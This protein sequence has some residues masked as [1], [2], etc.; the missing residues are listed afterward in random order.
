[1]TIPYS[2]FT[3]MTF[4]DDSEDFKQVIN[5]IDTFCYENPDQ[6][7]ECDVHIFRTI[8]PLL[9]KLF[10][11]SYQAADTFETRRHSLGFDVLDR[12]TYPSVQPAAPP[13]ALTP[14]QTPQTTAQ[15]QEGVKK[16]KKNS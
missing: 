16:K 8:P 7:L 9:E 11:I 3:V 5:D 12:A 15:S 1:V 6:K 10:L 4:D 14:Q 2:T 13:P